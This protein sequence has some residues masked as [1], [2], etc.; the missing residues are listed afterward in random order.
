MIV[1]DVIVN[2]KITETLKPKSQRLRDIYDFVNEQ[3]K[4]LGRKYGYH[5]GV[6]L[7]RRIIY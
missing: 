6:H 1:F 7:K 2:G 3:M 5:D 4:L